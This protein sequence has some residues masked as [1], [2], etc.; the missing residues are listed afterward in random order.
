[1]SVD[2]EIIS[3]NTKTATS[4]SKES[5]TLNIISND[6]FRIAIC[7]KCRSLLRKI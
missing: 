1:M 4:F 2:G 7:N 6:P 5:G 3:D